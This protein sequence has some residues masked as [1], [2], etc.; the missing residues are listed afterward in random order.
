[1]QLS[2]TPYH[3]VPFLS[4]YIPHHPVLRTP[5]AHVSDQVSYPYR[6]TGKITVFY[7]LIFMFVDSSH[8]CES[9]VQILFIECLDVVRARTLR[10]SCNLSLPVY[11]IPSSYVEP[12]YTVTWIRKVAISR[13][14]TGT[15]GSPECWYGALP[16]RQPRT[17]LRFL[18][19][20]ANYTD[21]ATATCCRS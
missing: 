20:R 7:V 21:R 10:Q 14:R 15:F 6:T 1:M 4:K 17:K 19:P 9:I 18:S 5:S 13:Q 11:A 2:P 16:S 12:L 8:S 3:F